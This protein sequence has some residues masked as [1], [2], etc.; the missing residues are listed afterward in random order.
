MSPITA[1]T[2]FKIQTMW[3][4]V[5]ANIVFEKMVTALGAKDRMHPE[6]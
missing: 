6:F 1:P 5:G 4:R 2:F 3:A